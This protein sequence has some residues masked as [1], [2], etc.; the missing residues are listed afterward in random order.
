M[1]VGDAFRYDGLSSAIRS[2]T[3]R[4]QSTQARVTSGKRIEKPSDDAS[5]TRQLLGIAQIRSGI[6]GY[7]K[8][9]DTAK[10]VLASSE[11]AYS[12]L[13]DL[14]QSATTLAIQGATATVDQAQRDTIAD[15]IQTLQD[16]LVALG[17][18]Q[19]PDGRY[20]FGGQATDAKP[21]SVNSDGTLAYAGNATVPTTPTGP[22]QSVRTGETGDA[23]STLYANLSKLQ[24]NLRSGSVAT[25]SNTDLDALK[26][27]SDALASAQGD[28]GRRLNV[29]A[30]ARTTLSNQDTELSGRASEI[31]DVDYATAI[32]DYTAAQSAYQAALTVASKGFSMGLMDFIK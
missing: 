3:D 29:I 21:F 9:L 22:G 11:S 4:V 18:S 12:D 25:I 23:V 15:Q 1:R 16:R 6:A 19:A 31:G 30:A 14:A 5:G 8:N 17:N 20:L 24:A 13:G 2:A 32:V 26:G 28:V 10:G 27:S 7:T